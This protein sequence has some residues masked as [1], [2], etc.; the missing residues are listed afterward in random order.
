MMKWLGRD[1]S[2]HGLDFS[3]GRD[4]TGT[5]CVFGRVSESSLPN[6][7]PMPSRLHC[8]SPPFF[9]SRLRWERNH[10]GGFVAKVISPTYPQL[11]K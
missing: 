1:E 9:L 10:R 4:P 2:R 11:S 7:Q 5:D 3:A 8:G 6:S